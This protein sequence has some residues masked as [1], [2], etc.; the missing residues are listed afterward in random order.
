MT[1][2]AVLVA[3]VLGLLALTIC[4]SPI[5]VVG[6]LFMAVLF[7]F[8]WTA[9][10]LEIGR[11]LARM[12]NKDWAL[13]VSAGVGTFLLTLVWAGISELGGV[14]V[15]CGGWLL[16]L[17]PVVLALGSAVMTFF[18]TRAYPAVAPAAVGPVAAEALPPAP[19]AE[20]KDE[21]AP[22]PQEGE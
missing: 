17:V 4:L 20:S 21:A 19:P 5:S 1:V 10:G 13:P 9:V 2:L 8:G 12:L 14:F 6:Y 22:P 18:G 11:R 7:I 16:L 15:L 3:I